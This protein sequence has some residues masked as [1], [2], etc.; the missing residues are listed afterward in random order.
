MKKHNLYKTGL[1]AILFALYG[2]LFTACSETEFDA[3]YMVHP[4][5]R[6]IVS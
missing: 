5:F 6:V 4:T 3:K 2:G 1:T